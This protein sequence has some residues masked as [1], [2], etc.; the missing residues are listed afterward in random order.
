MLPNFLIPGVP[1]AGTTSMYHYLSNH[2]EIFMSPK[3]EL[4][5][6][7]RDD[8]FARGISWYES[9]FKDYCSEKA[10]GEASP[11]YLYFEKAIRRISFI[12]PDVK[13]IIM[14]RNPVDRAYSHY[15]HNVKKN[16]E[17][18]NFAEAIDEEEYRI[19]NSDDAM[20]R[21]GYLHHGLYYDQIER[22]L[23]YFKKRQMKIIL[24]EEFIKEKRKILREIFHF[25]NVREDVE[26]PNIDN[27]FNIGQS[28]KFKSL[29]RVLEK[30]STLKRF[31]KRLFPIRVRKRVLEGLLQANLKKGY[32]H[33]EEKLMKSMAE[34]FVSP[35]KKLA[36]LLGIDLVCWNQARNADSE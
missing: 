31:Y 15:W 34:Y 26:I 4:W 30:D 36:D 28:Q 8:N 9:H 18:L 17:T 35:N 29:R 32:P 13:L 21:Y 33:I 27:R 20:H 12:I 25:L 16:Q 1:K 14:L 19:K 3:K 7:S 6:F 24:F 23:N 10:V 11:N 22:A 5:F 2:P